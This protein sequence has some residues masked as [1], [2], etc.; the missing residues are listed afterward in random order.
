MLLGNQALQLSMLLGNQDGMVSFGLLG[1][2][3]RS[4]PP[5]SRLLLKIPFMR[6]RNFSREG[7]VP[8]ADKAE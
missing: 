7:L 2:E 3:E 8:F 6:N 5:C 1:R 4:V